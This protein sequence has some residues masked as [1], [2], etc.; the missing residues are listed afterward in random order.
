MK[1][2]PII[3]DPMRLYELG[4]RNLMDMAILVHIGRCGLVG[5]KRT[6]ISEVMN[7]SYETARSGVDRLCDLGLLT[8][9]SRDYR[10]G[11]PHN[12]VCTVR[13]WDLLTKP[14][15]FSMFPHSQLALENH[16][17]KKSRHTTPENQTPAA[18]PPGID[19]G[20]GSDDDHSPDSAADPDTERKAAALG[21]ETP[22]YETGAG[23]GEAQYAESAVR[24]EAAEAAGIL[25][26]LPLADEA[27]AG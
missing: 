4:L 17:R 2:K 7:V 24:G 10:A 22:G 20:A 26:A 11:C 18:H 3:A 13:G 21:R 23:T 14:A 1:C 16:A 9:I 25:A 19:L 6:T 12:F 5:A 27:P 15:D 8:S